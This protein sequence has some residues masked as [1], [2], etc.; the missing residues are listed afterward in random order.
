MKSPSRLSTNEKVLTWIATA[1]L[2]GG[3][4]ATITATVTGA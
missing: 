4:I 2:V 1:V 3:I